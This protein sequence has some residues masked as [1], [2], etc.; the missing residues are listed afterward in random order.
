MTVREFNGTTDEL[1]TSIGAASG[2]V[3]GTVAT[4]VKFSTLSGFRDWTML[5][6]SGG[7]YAWSPNGLTNFSTLQMDTHGA[8]SDSGIN[9]GT[10][11]WK[12][13]VVRKATGSNAPRFSV[14][15]YSSGTWTHASGGTALANSGFAPGVGGQIR[16]TY[17]GSG[18]FFGGR[19]AARALWSNSLPWTADAAGDAAIEAAHLHTSARHWQQASPTVFQ[20]FN[21]SS[22]ATPVD[23][24]STAGTADQTSL[25]GT[26][27]VT[28][29]DPPGF[30]FSLGITPLFAWN[31][32]EASGDALDINTNG[33]NLVFAS[34]NWQRVAGRHN[35]GLQ[36]TTTGFTIG[37]SVTPLLTAART[38]MFD[39]K[40]LNTSGNWWI[41]E[42][43][44]ST[45]MGGAND[46]G[47]WGLLNLSSV[48]RWRAKNASNVATDITITPDIGN[49]HNICAAASGT[50]LKVYIDGTLL[51]SATVS[52]G[53]WN[54]ADTFRLFD[55][56]GTAVVIDNVRHFDE[57]LDATTIA[58]LAGTPVSNAVG[59]NVY[60]SN[61]AQASGIY[62]M[63]AGGV[64]VQRNNL[65]T[66]K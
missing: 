26:A 58:A 29:D 56:A 48:L 7:L 41:H 33:R 40:I 53:L 2:M 55:S 36:Q 27:V 25:V 15:D 65:I 8:N 59:P 51:G 4:L 22:T 30:S 14:Y 50:S 12:L 42:V 9:P 61:G 34:N 20:L 35:T 5:H 38:T 3:Y 47:I 39:I 18:D 37:P 10:T 24:L 31:A 6:D 32:D 17:Q 57:E 60:F 13:I 66:I 23:D 46:T 28:N 49:W 62:E 43:Y 16:T 1:V 64:L 21:Q 44:R 54:S 52:G 19:L 11:S 45:A 63:T